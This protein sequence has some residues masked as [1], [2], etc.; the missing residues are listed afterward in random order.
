MYLEP[1]RISAMQLF[2]ENRK[3]R[4]AVDYFANKAP[5]QMFDWVLSTSL[6]LNIRQTNYK[7]NYLLIYGLKNM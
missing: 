4:K 1:S 7:V 3:Q 2:C 6:Y 5:S